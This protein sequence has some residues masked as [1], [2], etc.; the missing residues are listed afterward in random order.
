MAFFFLY[1]LLIYIYARE[2]A[3]KGREKEKKNGQKN[4]KGPFSAL[5]LGRIKGNA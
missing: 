4:K 3:R 2:T 1:A 5:F